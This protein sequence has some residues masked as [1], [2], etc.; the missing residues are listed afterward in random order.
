MGRELGARFNATTFRQAIPAARCLYVLTNWLPM[1]DTWFRQTSIDREIW[2]KQN[3]MSDD[4][5]AAEWFEEVAYLKP[6]LSRV[7]NRWL[8]AY[9]SL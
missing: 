6:Y 9:R 1:I 8:M 5:L 2:L 3:Q 4:E 7:F